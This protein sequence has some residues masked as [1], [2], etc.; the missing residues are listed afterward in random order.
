MLSNLKTLRD[1]SFK[2]IAVERLPTNTTTRA[3]A[4]HRWFNFIAG[5]S[6]ELV[7]A[8][9]EMTGQA[10]RREM[11]LLDPFS[12]CG[13][14][15]VAARLIGISA[16][17][18]DPH[19]FFA[20][21]SEAK[22]NSAHYWSD[23]PRIQTAIERGIGDQP[24]EH[25]PLSDSAIAFLSKLVEPKA[26]SALNSARVELEND[27]LSNNPLA[28]LILSRILDHCCSAATDGIYKAPTSSK[29]P[30]SPK[31]ALARVMSIILSDHVDATTN[32][33]DIQIYARSSESMTEQED[34][35]IDIVVTSPPY[36]NNFDFAEMT[37]MYLYFWKMASSWSDISNKVR[38]QLVVNTTTALKGH[39]PLQQH[40][41]DS[42]PISVRQAAD[43]VVTTLVARR[44][45]KAG[46]KE[47]DFLIYPYLS[48]MQKVLAETY[49]TLK[50]GAPF[51]MMVS[52]AA[53]YGVHV[54]APQWLAEIMIEI[55]FQDVQCEMIRPRGH[56]WIL[57]KRAGSDEGLGEYYIFGVA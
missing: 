35:S 54:P 22:A 6:P 56:R 50:S 44:K 36:L 28:I 19:P 24:V 34:S 45:E 30:L 32:G 7:N 14:A 18:Y 5:F 11:R 12:G 17:A 57:D 29:K 43:K 31:D 39:K 3:H 46:K 4:V 25:S 26:L 42:L 40:Y 51:H 2:A 9:V 55:G 38:S 49:R 52:D 1:T 8:C 21:I 16:A 20:V 37:R 48:Q 13:T 15:P 23:L 47:Y 33:T 53:L 27:G 41:R 10:P